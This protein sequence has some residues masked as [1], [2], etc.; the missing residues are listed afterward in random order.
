MARAHHWTPRRCWPWRRCSDV[1]CRP[2]DM[3]T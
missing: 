1:T 2:R 3:L